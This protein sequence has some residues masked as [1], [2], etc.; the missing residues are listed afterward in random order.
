MRNKLFAIML[1]SII[2]GGCKPAYD[3]QKASFDLYLEELDTTLSYEM[4]RCDESSFS[5]LE[6][7]T[8]EWYSSIFTFDYADIKYVDDNKGL[9][10]IV[11]YMMNKYK[12]NL[13]TTLWHNYETDQSYFILNYRTWKKGKY[14]FSTKIIPII[15]EEE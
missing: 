2:I 15:D 13:S 14:V 10:S 9:A 11:K 8:I 5:E 3:W 1:L 6:N 4:Y 12:C 7:E